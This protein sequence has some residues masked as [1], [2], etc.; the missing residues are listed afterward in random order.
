MPVATPMTRSKKSKRV[1]GMDPTLEA[2]P[3]ESGISY[4]SNVDTEMTG[5]SLKFF[6]LEKAVCRSGIRMTQNSC[7]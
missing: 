7:T 6:L 2:A 1:S 4:Q 5:G 3:R